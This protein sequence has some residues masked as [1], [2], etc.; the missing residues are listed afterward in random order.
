MSKGNDNKVTNAY[1]FGLIYMLFNM[2]RACITVFTRSDFGVSAF[3]LVGA[4]AFLGLLL[5]AGAYPIFRLYLL[6]WVLMLAYR[7][8]ESIR[9]R[10]KGEVIHSGYGGYP[11]PAMKLPGVKTE[12]QGRLME[13]LLCLL[14]GSLICWINQPLG[15]FIELGFISL[16][17][18]MA[19]DELIDWK[20][21]Q[22]MKDGE[23]EM[24]YYAQRY[25]GR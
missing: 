17:G 19:I 2:H 20:R 16:L 11:W 21:V 6:A 4:P 12:R 15:L 22:A 5:L 9:C 7:R 23:I 18:C 24:Q 1:A 13:P 8:I 25:R 10:W 14:V 3:D